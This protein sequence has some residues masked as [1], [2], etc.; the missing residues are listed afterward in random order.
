MPEM[1]PGSRIEVRQP[2]VPSVSLYSPAA[3]WQAQLDRMPLPADHM[4]RCVTLGMYGNSYGA[5]TYA[6][7]QGYFD[8]LKSA[9][10]SP[11]WANYA[12]SQ[13]LAADACSLA[14]GTNAAQLRQGTA[15]SM[16]S[17]TTGACTYNGVG[18]APGSVWIIDI[19]RNDAGFDGQTASSGTTAKSRAGFRNGLDALIR[20]LRA[21]HVVSDSDA[22]F[23]YTGSWATLTTNVLA[24]GSAHYTFTANDKVTITTPSGTDFDLVLIAL[25]S[26]T[27]TGAP[28]E[29]RVDG[30]LVASGTTHNQTRKTQLVLNAGYSQMT[31]PLRGLSAGVHSIELKHVGSNGQFLYTDGLLVPSTHPPTVIVNK[32]A[33]LPAAGYATYNNWPGVTASS[34]SEATDLIYDALIDDVIEPFAGDD[35]VLAFDPKATGFDTDTMIGGRDGA[36]VHL[37]DRGNAFYAG[38]LLKIIRNLEPRVGLVIGT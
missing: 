28:Y 24:S 35:S 21:D 22:S 32:T 26:V 37:N 5:V 2:A 23:V 34:A 29:V 30:S 15:A 9:I 27:G 12:V 16:W 6:C 4:L 20:L 18:N 11:I 38:Q 10:G 36:Y 13:S 31:V 25:D 1:F 14:Y 19:A 8:R 17:A 7:D 33:P 3:G